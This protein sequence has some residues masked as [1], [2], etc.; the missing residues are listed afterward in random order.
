M[1]SKQLRSLADSATPYNM[2]RDIMRKYGTEKNGKLQITNTDID[3]AVNDI[4][5]NFG[6]TVRNS[7]LNDLLSSTI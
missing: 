4:F 1:A 3:Y 2:F 7:K 6:Y 5:N